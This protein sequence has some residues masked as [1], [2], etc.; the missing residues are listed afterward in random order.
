MRGGISSSMFSLVASV[1]GIEG[2]GGVWC[3]ARAGSSC[4]HPPCCCA[5]SATASCDQDVGSWERF[6]ARN[7]RLRIVRVPDAGHLPWLDEPKRVVERDRTLSE[8]HSRANALAPQ[9]AAHDHVVGSDEPHHE[10]H[11]GAEYDV[12]DRTLR[13]HRD[14]RW[15][16]RARYW[17]LPEAQGR[18]F[19][20]LDAN[21]RIGDAW[22][23]RW[24]SLRL[25]TPAPF[26][27]LP[28][29]LFPAGDRFPTK[30]AMADYLEAYA[31]QF[32]LPVR[33]GVRVDCLTRQGER[34]VVT[35]GVRRYEAENV[36]VAMA[37]YQRPRIPA[38]A[39]ELDPEIV[40]LHSSA[41]RNP[42]QLREGGVL[43][44]GAGNSG[45]DIAMEIVRSHPTW[46]SG[47]DVGHIPFRIESQVA[48]LV[49]R[50]LFRVVFHRVLT[51]DTPIGRRV[52]QQ[53][54][55]G[56]DPLIRVKP[57]D[58]T[59]AGVVR[60]PK[61]VGAQDGRPQLEDGRTLNVAN[62]IWCTGY[63]PGFSWIDLPVF[64]E[65]KTGRSRCTCAAWSRASQDST[66]SGLEFL[67]AFSS[68]MV[69]GVSRDAEYVVQDIARRTSDRAVRQAV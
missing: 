38:F 55:S 7:A 9:G 40:Q 10:R 23:K 12:S 63:E 61:V 31:A 34:F 13:H 4:V 46:L 32:Q 62:V 48:P 44:V 35:A 22:R 53:F 3:W 8:R 47:R 11:E 67:Y 41:Y 39:A 66:S 26:D 54:H 69:Q 5:V 43:I 28:G 37:N 33:T 49:V 60:V 42:S 45:A 68:A 16:G 19:I 56:G 36:V 15:A 30:D 6:A 58:L 64:G 27:S 1:G 29:M 51:V 17:L 24:D 57:K 2:C 59:A 25:F 52:R 65:G 50:P 20:I 14:R 18:D 21:A